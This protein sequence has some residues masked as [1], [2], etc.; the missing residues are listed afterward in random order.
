MTST[1]T[2]SIYRAASKPYIWNINVFDTGIARVRWS[3]V[4][5][6]KFVPWRPALTLTGTSDYAVNT[7]TGQITSHIDTW[8]ALA[9]NSYL[10]VSWV[11]AGQRLLCV[12][13]RDCAACMFA[14]LWA[15]PAPPD[16]AMSTA[17]HPSL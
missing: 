6:P 13:S 11:A 4:L 7:A 15:A 5:K 17:R 12:C 14:W 10:S 16:L 8:D 1:D 2:C 3:M 9:D